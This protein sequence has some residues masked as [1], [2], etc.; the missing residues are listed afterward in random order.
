MSA[1]GHDVTLG[2][3][4]ATELGNVTASGNFLGT[5]F[6]AVTQAI[7][8]ILNIGGTT[9]I[10]A[11]SNNI[12]LTNANELTGAVSLTG[13]NISLVQ[14]GTLDLG[15]IAASGNVILAATQLDNTVG[16]DAITTGTGDAWG[17][18]L[19]NLSGNTFDGLQSGNQAI[20]NTSSSTPVTESGNRYIFDTAES[21]TLGPEATPFSETK[22]QGDSITLPDPIAGT[23]YQVSGFVYAPKY[24]NAFTQDTVDNVAISGVNYTS[25]GVPVSAP[26]ATYPITMAGTAAATRGYTASYDP[27]AEFG[28]LTVNGAPIP[29]IP[30]VPP[31]PLEP[32]VPPNSNYS[33]PS[34]VSNTIAPNPLFD[35]D[36][37]VHDLQSSQQ[38]LDEFAA[39]L[40]N[41]QADDSDK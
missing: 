9:N 29:P 34:L 22:T 4:D 8:K 20:W 38:V 33:N 32:A 17:I 12:T 28:E 14:N 31:A 10:D 11:E 40:E 39:S 30:P 35:I 6:G 15:T 2:N 13:N 21:L 16:S 23:N 18:Y 26:A 1:S 37:F 5:F 36:S 41:F 27:S 3:L 19:S 7:G 25:E 24:D